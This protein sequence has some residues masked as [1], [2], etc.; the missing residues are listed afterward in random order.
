MNMQVNEIWL[1][2]LGLFHGA[3]ILHGDFKYQGIG[4][5]SQVVLL[6]STMLLPLM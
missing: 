4:V 1:Y 3:G 5:I 6:L 2:C